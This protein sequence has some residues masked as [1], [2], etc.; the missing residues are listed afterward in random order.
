MKNADLSP[1]VAAQLLVVT[2]KET[3][4]KRAVDEYYMVKKK[5]IMKHKDGSEKDALKSSGLW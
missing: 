5:G 4:V 2:M 1:G 3:D